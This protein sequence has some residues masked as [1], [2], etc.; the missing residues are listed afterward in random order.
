MRPSS[1]SSTLKSYTAQWN[2]PL[3]AAGVVLLVGSLV[4]GSGVGAWLA[5]GVQRVVRGAAFVPFEWGGENREAWS[6]SADSASAEESLEVAAL[7]AEVARLQTELDAV[8][9]WESFRGFFPQLMA[10]VKPLQNLG[11]VPNARQRQIWVKLDGPGSVAIGQ[12]ILAAEGFLGRV[13]KVEDSLAV[14]QLLGDEKL[15]LGARL[16]STGEL[17]LVSWDAELEALVFVPESTAT[18]LTVGTPVVTSGLRGS[19]VL[20]G[21]PVGRMAKVVQNNRGE[22]VGIVE[23]A[24]SAQR[25]PSV[26]FALF[27]GGELEP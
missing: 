2:P 13:E 21:I 3:L 16:N 14:V 6:G 10:E 5:G 24:V 9:E 8:K 19:T 25:Q 11:R 23:P 18:E 27:T 12:T 1:A 26:V 22:W 4:V 7:R 20:Q 17:G 15:K